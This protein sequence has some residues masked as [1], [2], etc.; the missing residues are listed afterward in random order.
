MDEKPKMVWS[1]GY[2]VSRRWHT[3]KI[4]ICDDSG[5][6]VGTITKVSYRSSTGWRRQ[7]YS[8][9]M[10]SGQEVR[11]KVFDISCAVDWRDYGGR[12]WQHAGTSS[13][14]RQ[15]LRE[16]KRYATEQVRC[17]TR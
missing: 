3:R 13:S 1:A 14:L 10:V 11:R 6:L 9:L 4:D 12:S 8:V 15:A 17:I 5:Q 16:A 7:G 2:D